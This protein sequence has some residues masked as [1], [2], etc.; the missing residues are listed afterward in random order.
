MVAILVALKLCDLGGLGLMRISPF[1]V[2]LDA[3]ILILI[4]FRIVEDLVPTFEQK[5]FLGG[6]GHGAHGV[7]PL[8]GR[9]L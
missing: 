6:K 2:R 8:A 5:S 9:S 1:A 3:E 4:E 7:F